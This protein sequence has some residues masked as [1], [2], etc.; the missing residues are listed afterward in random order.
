MR[1]IVED[2][3]V[4]STIP[5]KALYK[6]LDKVIYCVSDAIVEDMNNDVDVT[7]LDMGI[8]TLY[9]KH[10]EGTVA[11]KFIPN[12]DF[13][14]AVNSTIKTGQNLLSNNLDRALVK[15]FLDVYKDI[16]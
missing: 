1:S 9:I 4:L 14:K 13:S 5:D 10:A 3:S 16:C 6:L 15:K 8:G 12:S 2:I 11:Y 7:E